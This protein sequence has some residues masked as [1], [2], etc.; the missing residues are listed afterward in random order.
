MSPASWVAITKYS[1]VPQPNFSILYR[2][3]ISTTAPSFHLLKSNCLPSIILSTLHA[4]TFT[5][6]G[7]KVW[8]SSFH[9]QQN[10]G[11]KR[12]VNLPMVIQLVLVRV[13]NVTQVSVTPKPVCGLLSHITSWYVPQWRESSH[14]LSYLQTAVS[15]TQYMKTS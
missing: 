12:L 11:H 15:Y 4:F 5:E 2:F 7:M 1:Q 9:R 14:I 13:R 8:L 3:C 6:A 10:W